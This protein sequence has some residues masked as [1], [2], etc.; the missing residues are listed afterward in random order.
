MTSVSTEGLR[1]GLLD[2]LL[3][4]V[5]TIEAALA[6]GGSEP[7]RLHTA[8]RH[9]ARA[10]AVGDLL[11]AIDWTPNDALL[12]YRLDV[13]ADGWAAATALER[14]IARQQYAAWSEAER[15]E[16][17]NAG[18]AESRRLQAEDDLAEIQAACRKA[19]IS[20]TAPKP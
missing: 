19:G 20:I 1:L 12:T 5:R 17:E 2:V 18:E 16:P 7:Q 11:G 4:S 10:R 15:D 14:V 8:R 6:P 3:D 13:E 9:Y